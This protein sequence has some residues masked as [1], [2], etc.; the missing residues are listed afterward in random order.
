MNLYTIVIN[1]LKIDVIIGVLEEER[2]KSQRVVLNAKIEY[3]LNE[4][5]LD[6]VQV[7]EAIENL[8]KYKEYET[9]E[10]AL[11]GICKALK[12]DFPE[13]VSI[14]LQIFKPEVFKNALV[15]VEIFKEY[16]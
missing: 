14:K 10:S 11:S 13:I 5:F 4:F 2:K 15:G 6:Y 12:L 16:K 7:V 3:D 8:L 9:I 1:E